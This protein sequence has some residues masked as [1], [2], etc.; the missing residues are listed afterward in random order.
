VQ[1]IES[2]SKAGAQRLEAEARATAERLAAQSQAEVQ[3]LQTEADMRPLLHWPASSVTP[4]T[5]RAWPSGWRG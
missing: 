1:K 2:Q 3:R 5:C 4:P